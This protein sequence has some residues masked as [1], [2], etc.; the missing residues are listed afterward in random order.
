MQRG[1]RVSY[2]KENPALQEPPQLKCAVLRGCREII[3]TPAFAQRTHDEVCC[4]AHQE[5]K[6][7]LF[8]ASYSC[9]SGTMVF[10]VQLGNTTVRLDLL[11]YICG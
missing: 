5:P 1:G 11:C 4:T 9:S 7:L 6:W 10:T 8:F 3:I 2:D